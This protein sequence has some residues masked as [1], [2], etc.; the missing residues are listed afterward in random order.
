MIIPESKVT[1][2]TSKTG[3]KKRRKKTQIRSRMNWLEEKA[4]TGKCRGEEEKDCV[5]IGSEGVTKDMSKLCQKVMSID[6][7]QVKVSLNSNQCMFVGSILY[8]SK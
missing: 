7:H 6:S 3:E 8:S 2:T 5:V 4:V 1:A